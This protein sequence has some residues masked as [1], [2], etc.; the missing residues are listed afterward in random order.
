M[1][2]LKE[3]KEE[4]LDKLKFPTI[5]G[6]DEC[7]AEIIQEELNKAKIEGYKEGLADYYDCV[8]QDNVNTYSLLIKK[9]E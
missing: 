6:S 2:T 1:K 9:E 4:I 7:N 3:I 5:V 8:Q